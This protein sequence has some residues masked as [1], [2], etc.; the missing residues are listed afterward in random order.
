MP[1]TPDAVASALALARADAEHPAA[2][3]LARLLAFLSSDPLPISILAATASHLPESLSTAFSGDEEREKLLAALRE[4]ELAGGDGDAVAMPSEVRD[5]VREAMDAD[6]RRRWAATAAAVMV[7][8]FPPE[9]EGEQARAAAVPLIKH[10]AT[11]AVHCDELETATEDAATLLGLA[12]RAVLALGQAAAARPFLERALELRERALG[13]AAPRVAFDLTWLNGALLDA[14]PPE[15]RRVAENAE[16]ALRIFE[17][18]HGPEGRTTLV[19]VNNTGTLYR[20]AGDLPAARAF[21]E[22][23]MELATR[24]YG[25]AHPFYA[26]ISSNLG[27]VLQDQ[28]DLAGARAL[29]ERALAVDEGAY[30]RTNRSVVRD[31]HKLASILSRVGEPGPARPLLERVVDFWEG[32]GNA[33]QARTVRG[34]LD[35]LAQSSE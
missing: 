7:R 8:A 30:G 12:G 15:A 14:G 33:A 23:A 17:T 9:P 5:A 18:V 19:H 21:L 31:L 22:H 1:L 25:T 28:G 11:A 34:E 32:E 4:M 2:G 26:T 16:R 29:Y 20:R 35:A 6:E 3:D 24:V 10:A 27:D 13:P